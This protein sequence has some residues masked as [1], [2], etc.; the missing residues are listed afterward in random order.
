MSVNPTRGVRRKGGG[1]VRMRGIDYVILYVSDLERA[2]AF[3]EQSLGLE[4]RVAGDGYVEFATE[5]SKLGLFERSRLPDLIGRRGGPAGEILFI[6]EDVD[7][8]AARL[9]RLGVEIIA[10]PVDRPWGHR[11]L[12]LLGPDGFVIELA[13][14]IPRA[15]RERPV[16]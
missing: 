16:D 7:T 8:E 13:Q 14:Q 12:H 10:G 9:R 1:I 4:R 11:T 2:A 15:D 5:N 6:V 3:Y